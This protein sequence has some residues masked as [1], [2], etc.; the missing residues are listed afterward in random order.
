MFC[1]WRLI[2]THYLLFMCLNRFK[3]QG[4][5]QT[6]PYF[7]T[8]CFLFLIGGGMR[9]AGGMRI[10]DTLVSVWTRHFFLFL[11]DGNSLI[12]YYAPRYRFMNEQVTGRPAPI[13][14]WEIKKVWEGVVELRYISGWMISSVLSELWMFIYMQR[15]MRLAIKYLLIRLF[16]IWLFPKGWQA[17][18]LSSS[19]KRRS[20]HHISVCVTLE[21]S[22]TLKGGCLGRLLVVLLAPVIGRR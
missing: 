2:D 1:S 11:P 4:L 5:K 14:F 17:T 12:I 7:L 8:C 19:C 16:W 9:I 22:L 15:G 13:V 20:R 6:Y 3:W 21:S 10:S 18:L